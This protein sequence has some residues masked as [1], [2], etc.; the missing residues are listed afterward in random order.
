MRSNSELIEELMSWGQKNEQI[1]AMI[2]WGSLENPNAFIDIFSDIDVL[3]IVKDADDFCK[4]DSWREIFGKIISSWGEEGIWSNS[5]LVRR[6]FRGVLYE[7]GNKIDFGI[8]DVYSFSNTEEE[9]FDIGYKVIIDKDALTKN[10]KKPTYS[11]FTTNKP[12]EEE[13]LSQINE[14]WWNT[15]YVGRSLWRDEAFFA[16]WILE[17]DTCFMSLQNMVEWYIG[18]NNNWSVN[19]NKHGRWFKRYLDKE[20]WHELGSTFTGANIEDNWNALFKMINL[21]TRLAV[22]VG[23]SLGYTYPSEIG[24]GVLKYLMKVKSLDKNAISFK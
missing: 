23:D 18:A 6:Y 24:E 22:F 8:G 20:T 13:Y 16:K 19:P 14:F 3:L 4:D 12:T 21:F 1:R 5:C 17:C 9:T 11:L 10:L 7:D 15:T 2:L